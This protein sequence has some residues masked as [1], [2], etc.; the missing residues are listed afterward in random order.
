MGITETG[1][2]RP[3]Q[4]DIAADIAADQR[5]TISAQLDV[6]EST[7]IGNLNAIFADRLALAYEALEEAYFGNDPDNATDA[8]FVSLALL[9]GTER[10]DAQP[11]SVTITCNLAASTVF[12]AGDLVVH[13]VD[14]PTNRWLNRDV[15][16]STTAG[17]YDIT[18]L[19]EISGVDAVA[20]AGT[21]T[22]IASP[23]EGFNAATNAEDAT[24]G[25]EQESI[26]ELRVRREQELAL[27]GSGTVDAIRADVLETEGVIECLVEENT[28][29]VAVG[30]LPA[31]SFRVVVWDGDP[32]AVDNDDIA[33]V[34]LASGP[35]GIV[36]AGS[37]V[38]TAARSDGSTVTRNFER[39][40]V[41]DIYIEADIVSEIGVAAANVKA[42]L[43]AAMPTLIGGDVRYNKLT[44][45]VFIDG[46][47]DF[48]SFTVGVAPSPVG[49][50]NIAISNTQIAQLDASNIV[51]TGDVS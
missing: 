11:G 35:A 5:G 14:D 31:H 33:Q 8:R 7:V 20:A 42:A 9:T 12:A 40:A 43:A 28:T 23:I 13:A 16:E 46:V 45:A 24:A 49:T 30:D 34:I 38:G 4:A 2:E 6:S 47:D 25:R 3:I 39:A 27:G 26:E 18:F 44:A 21:L 51:L 41:V 10:R 22:V 48:T 1:F 17:D 29:D 36:S 32:G 19:S 50:A 37:Q 15:V